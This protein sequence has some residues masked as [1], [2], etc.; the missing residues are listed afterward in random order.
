MRGP[1]IEGEKI[2]LVPTEPEFLAEFVRWFADMR[3]TRFL[4]RRF[5]M[6]L[7]EEQ[8]WYSA[9][10]KDPNSVHWT[11][12]VD[13]RPIGVTGIHKIDWI[14]RGAITGTVIGLPEEW[15]K[16][17]ATES[18]K[19]RTRFAFEELNLNRLESQSMAPNVGMHKAL[20]HVGHR[21]VGVHRQY[22]FR[23]GAYL[24]SVLFELLREDW[25]AKHSD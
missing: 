23:D 10:T 11:I 9:M 15:G 17:Y 20:D 2:R 22:I 16:G 12:A 1:L 18:V 24:D 5:P 8:E 21:R 19:L 3:V 6:T 25:V 4:L 13:G 14:A 7:S